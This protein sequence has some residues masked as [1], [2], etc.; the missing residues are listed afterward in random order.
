M[1]RSQRHHVQDRK[2]DLLWTLGASHAGRQFHGPS[3]IQ[4]AG[5]RHKYLLQR[6]PPAV[7]NDHHI[8]GGIV[9]DGI[10][11]RAK[12]L[13]GGF[14]ITRPAQHQEVRCVLDR[15]QSHRLCHVSTEPD[16]RMDRDI[17][18]LGTRDRFIQQRPGLL[19]Q[20]AAVS[21]GELTG[22][23][24][25]VQSEH[26]SVPIGGD[27]GPDFSQDLGLRLLADWN[28]HR[29][30]VANQDL[31]VQD[32]LGLFHLLDAREIAEIRQ[33]SN[34]GPANNEIPRH[35]SKPKQTDSQQRTEGNRQQREERHEGNLKA[36]VQ[37]RATP[38][39]V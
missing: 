15:G 25:H 26:L 28:Q 21:K 14:C 13:S 27:N 12:Q 16:D 6:P 8:R 23:L 20:Q 29:V 19:E 11:N 18:F 35:R 22:D 24:H 37:F 3:T 7:A 10:D 17:S 1:V 31:L 39:Q 36:A 5:H 30:V 9:D 38:P 2:R 34:N 32:L 4:P 33:C